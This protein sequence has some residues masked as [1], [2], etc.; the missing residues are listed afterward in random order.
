MV[1]DGASCPFYHMFFQ[2]IIIQTIHTNTNRYMQIH[3]N[4]HNTSPIQ[5]VLRCKTPGLAGLAQ[6]EAIHARGQSCAIMFQRTDG[7]LPVWNVRYSGRNVDFTDSR[8]PQ[9][10]QYGSVR[11][12]VALGRYMPPQS[13]PYVLYTL[14]HNV[15]R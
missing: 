15:H 14:K 8:S 1:L 6:A 9:T 7:N 13:S 4:T 10:G 5:T 3:T 11:L 12:S 2:Y